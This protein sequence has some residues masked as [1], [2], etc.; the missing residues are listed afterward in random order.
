MWN[1]ILTI[2]HLIPHFYTR[3]YVVS[4]IIILQILVFGIKLTGKS[5]FSDGKNIYYQK[6]TE[7]FHSRYLTRD[8]KIFNNW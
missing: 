5:D 7:R 8:L 3:M 1:E 4:H 2:T 6:Q